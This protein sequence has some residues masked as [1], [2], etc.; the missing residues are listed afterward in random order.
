MTDETL[1]ESRY[2]RWLVWY[3]KAY[4]RD[5]D[6][7][8]LAVLVA[9]S[10]DGQRHPSPGELIALVRG[11]LAMRLLPDLPRSARL[12]R[13]A[14]GLLCLAAA[15]EF[16][17]WLAVITT[18]DAVAANLGVRTVHLTLDLV[19]AP[20][21]AIALLLLAWAIGHG[22]RWGLGGLVTLVLLTT[23]GFLTAL[24]QGAA[25]YAPVDLI[26][27]GLAWLTT[28]A[29]TVLVLRTAAER[30]VAA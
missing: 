5:H 12:L 13:T 21:V 7:E 3:P 8:L 10:R 26:V 1:L 17:T 15:L 2:R 23:I 24:S 25:S 29:A 30:R 22:R 6:A 20:V 9:V 18:R 19:A 11:G 28:L 16:A 4:R 14:I 27:D